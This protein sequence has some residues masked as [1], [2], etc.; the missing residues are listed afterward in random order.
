MNP[1][2]STF[3]TKHLS[4]STR[5]AI[6]IELEKGELSGFVLNF[7]RV[8]FLNELHSKFRSSGSLRKET[9]VENRKAKFKDE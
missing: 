1:L 6:N 2:S 3:L 8:S 9:A 7:G 4:L 5:Q